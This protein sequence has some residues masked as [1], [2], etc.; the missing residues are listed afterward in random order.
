MGF[1]IPPLGWYIFTQKYNDE[2]DTDKQSGEPDTGNLVLAALIT[3]AV[4]VGGAAL[5]V[6]TLWAYHMFLIT[7][8][9]TTKEHWRGRQVQESI[10]GYGENL[11]IFGRRGRRLFNPR[12]VAEVV[13][14]EQGETVT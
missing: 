14:R 10:P 6:I 11:T 13:L 4:A 9:I 7:M 8:G 1:V 5:L 3:A 12:A 2:S